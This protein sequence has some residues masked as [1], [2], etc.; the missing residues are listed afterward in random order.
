MAFPIRRAGPKEPFNKPEGKEGDQ[1]RPLEQG[2]RGPESTAETR[3]HR[4]EANE[5]S[6]EMRGGG[7][8]G[9]NVGARLRTGKIRND[10]AYG[11]LCA[12]HSLSIISFNTGGSVLTD[13]PMK[14]K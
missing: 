3:T 12:R 11:Q 4:K 2:W 8:K 9:G 13:R 1:E 5:G 6:K 7:K 14:I 10:T